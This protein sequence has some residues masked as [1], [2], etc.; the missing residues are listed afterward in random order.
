MG[1]GRFSFTGMYPQMVS[2]SVISVAGGSLA[3]SANYAGYLLGA[4]IVSFLKHR[5]AVRLSRFATIGTIVCLALLSLHFGTPFIVVVRFVAGVISAISMVAT[6]IWLFH[7]VGYHHGAP[8]LYSGVGIGIMVSAELIALGSASG[9]NSAALWSLLA[10]MSLLMCAVAWPRITRPAHSESADHVALAKSTAEATPPFGAWTLVLVYGLAGFGYIVTATYLPLLVKDALPGINPVHVW[11]AF[12]LGAVPSCFFWH[13]LHHRLASRAAMAVNLVVQ[14]LGVIV[15]V[16]SHSGWAYIGSA[17]LV[18]GTFV[19]T[20]T[21]AM[22]MAKRVASAM[23]LNLI[24]T[25]T[26]AYGV[27]QIS[28]PLVSNALFARTHSFDQPLV[29]AGASLMVAAIACL[30]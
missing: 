15:P 11:A 5:H 3:A 14:A 24:A 30:R 17:I 19:G 18:G 16:L 29:V 25:M 27:G 12:G 2:E 21:I 22:S 20:V 7:V 4:I 8:I 10:A 26:A 6:S 23:K 28:G 1:I 13:W 9:F